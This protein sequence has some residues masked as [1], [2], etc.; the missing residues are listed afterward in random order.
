MLTLSTIR[1]T[2]TKENVVINETIGDPTSSYKL[3]RL[4][5]PISVELSDGHNIAIPE[6]FQHDMLPNPYRYTTHYI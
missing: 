3:F 4:H 6:G 1:E 5:Q 2:L